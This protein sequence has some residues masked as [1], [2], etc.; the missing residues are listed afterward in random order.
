MRI[1]GRLLIE[2]AAG[3]RPLPFTRL[4]L[5]RAGQVVA[6]ASSDRDGHFQFPRDLPH[7]SYELTLDSDRYQAQTTIT[8]NLSTPTLHLIANPLPSPPS[9]ASNP[10]L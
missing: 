5:S 1:R 9:R 7:A 10:P 3:L 8:L 6:H 2:G 4:A